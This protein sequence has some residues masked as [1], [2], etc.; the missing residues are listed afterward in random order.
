M[1]LK[2]EPASE[3]RVSAEFHEDALLHFASFYTLV[4]ADVI[5]SITIIS[6]CGRCTHPRIRW[7]VPKPGTLF[8][9]RVRMASASSP[10]ISTKPSPP[11]SPLSLCIKVRMA[12]AISTSTSAPSSL[13]LSSPSTTSPQPRISLPP[14]SPLCIKVF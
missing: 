12:S 4:L 7:S 1:R 5:P 10:S 2:Y 8:P 11:Y 14:T 3:S 13:P 9:R 6:P